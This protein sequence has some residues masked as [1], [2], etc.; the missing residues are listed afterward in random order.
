MSE[1]EGGLC[2]TG[3]VLE[4][5]KTFFYL[6]DFS[7]K[8][9][10]W[11]YNTTPTTTELQIRNLEGDLQAVEQVPVHEARRTLGVLLAPD[12]NNDAEFRSLKQK[13]QVWAS[14]ITTHQF[15]Q[16]YACTPDNHHCPV[17]IPTSR[18]NPVGST[19]LGDR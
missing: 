7:W 13:A 6:V 17:I 14:N 8:Q 4:P 11:S 10:K 3:G 15:S 2:A 16:K 5:A 19:V 1:W 12:G 9:G 18:H